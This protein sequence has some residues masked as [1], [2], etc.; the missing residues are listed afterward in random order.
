MSPPPPEFAVTAL[1]ASPA[2]E[3]VTV[4]GAG[5]MGTCCAKLLAENGQTVRLL[6]RDEGQARELSDRRENRRLLPGVSIPESILISHD[7][8]TAT[9]GADRL[10]IAVPT[11]Y[12]RDYLSQLAPQIQSQ[13]MP[14][15][16]AIS[17]VKGIEFG[18]FRRPSEIIRETLGDRPVTALGGPCHAEEAANRL[19]A[20]VVAASDTPGDA[21]AVQA[22]M[23]SDRFRVYTNEDLIGVELAGAL[24]NVIA[25]AAGICD[26]LGLGDN[27]KSALITRGAAEIA[28]FGAAFGADLATFAGLAGI[29]DLIT[30]C[31]SGHGRNRAVGERLGRG[32]PASAVTGDL[33]QV[34]EGVNTVRSVL[35]LAEEKRIRMPVCREVHAVLFEGKPAA[36]TVD[37]L[38]TRPPG[39]E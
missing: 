33:L 14:R 8:L 3:F 10:L 20:S 19:P 23:N 22:L 31:V 36:D 15:T 24:K 32:E 37:A 7:P 6:T 1:T 28:R 5:A 16:P 26:G 34:A 29:G 2:H 17:V 30:S 13:L 25:V 21:E 35:P 4:I 11:K 9:A 38:M 39:G 18:S 27:S 12:L